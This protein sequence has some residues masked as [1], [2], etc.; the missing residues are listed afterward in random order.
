MN[1]ENNKKILSIF[2]FL[3][4]VVNSNQANAQTD[5]SLTISVPDTI[6]LQI[7]KC[8]AEPEC[9]RKVA[10]SLEPTL[11]RLPDDKNPLVFRKSP[12]YLFYTSLSAGKVKQALTH[13]EAIQGQ[14]L[15]NTFC[16]LGYASTRAD[17]KI[18]PDYVAAGFTVLSKID[19]PKGDLSDAI[20]MLP[21]DK[22]DPRNWDC[23]YGFDNI[24]DK[25]KPTPT[26]EKSVLPMA[27]A[28]ENLSRNPF[29]W[30]PL[31]SEDLSLIHI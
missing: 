1:V 18:E 2:A 22:Q 4:L 27:R 9:Y 3:F 10:K 20:A 23:R 12:S 8:E 17:S 29:W 13:I 28:F 5:K 11:N 31:S 24:A 21:A 14:D 6:K 15:I 7:Q 30:N 26:F 25:L 19:L 16:G